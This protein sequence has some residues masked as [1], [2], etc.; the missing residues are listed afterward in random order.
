MQAPE[1]FGRTDSAAEQLQKLSLF[2]RTPIHII[3]IL[4][5]SLIFIIIV[6]AIP[7]VC[8]GIFLVEF[9]AGM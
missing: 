6:V 4:I 5:V 8:G 3:I 9:R 1:A 7:S 2:G